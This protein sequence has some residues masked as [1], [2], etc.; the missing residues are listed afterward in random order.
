ME[1][2]FAEE[3]YDKKADITN[4][5]YNTN[6]MSSNTLITTNKTTNGKTDTTNWEHNTKTKNK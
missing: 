5:K 6:P 1:N 2:N 3:V 4:R